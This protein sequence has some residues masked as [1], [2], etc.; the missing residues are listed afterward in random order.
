[1]R[2][3][4][5][6]SIKIIFIITTIILVWLSVFSFLR[7]ES[8]INASSWVNHT[9]LVK[10]ELETAISILNEARSDQ[11]GFII[12]H[13]SVFYHKF[14]DA[15]KEEYKYLHNIDSLVKDNPAQVTNTRMLKELV[16]GSIAALRKNIKDLTAYN[17]L[18]I[19]NFEK[20]EVTL[21]DVRKQISKM[22]AIEDVLLKDRT[23]L[24]DKETYATPLIIALLICIA[25]LI[26][27]IFYF[28]INYDLKKSETL[29][30]EI[31]KTNI[32]LEEKNKLLVQNEELLYKIFENNPIAMS[33]SELGTKKIIYANS[34]FYSYFQLTPAEVIGT[35]SDH[36]KLT[37][38]EENQRLVAI[39]MKALN[40]SRSVEELRKLSIEE[41]A[42]LLNILKEK[43]FKNGYE[44]LY[45]RKNGETFYAMFFFEITT[46]GDK[47]YTI[48]SYLDISDKK[49]AEAE[50]EKMNNE[51]QKETEAKNVAEQKKQVAEATAKSKQQFLAHMSH[52]IRTP[53]NS[54]LGFTNVLFRTNLNEEQKGYISAIKESGDALL[55]IINDILDITKVDAGKM[56]FEK[57]G[58]NLFKSVSA[59]L[60]LIDDKIKEKNLEYIKEF[61]TGIPE[62]VVGDAVRLRQILLNLVSNAAKFTNHGRITV[63]IHKLKEDA[64]TVTLEFIVK[65]TGIG[66]P[67]D[68]QENIFNSFEQ[69]T[70]DTSRLYGGT[71]LGLAIVKK[72]V[73]L[74]GGIVSLE[75]EP[76]KGSSFGFVLSFGNTETKLE[77]ENEEV[78]NLKL[79]IKKVFNRFWIYS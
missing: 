69:A 30:S 43:M 57:T 14:N 67:K 52:E 29:K 60:H 58:F 13:D 22:D 68:K 31:V 79:D 39:I 34:L 42:K 28:K 33:F 15:V 76:G 25:I 75:S 54:I 45:T 17:N 55:I 27:V 3:Y 4:S 74:Q 7:M 51:L 59:T 63:S 72:F 5:D 46:L 53:M 77:K 61:D 56:V 47:K 37:S 44:I 1:M 70:N 71:G 26:L 12:S 40:E 64:E 32:M 78:L 19:S 35:N 10:L 65:D 11:R 62:I 36:L 48:A 23:L 66:I 38:D 2:K 24:L 50:I 16:E 6:T 20:R 21:D 9:N 41:S 18:L 73:E 49:K 8:L